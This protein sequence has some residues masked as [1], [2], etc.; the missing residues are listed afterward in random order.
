[1]TRKY[2]VVLALLL[3]LVA[4]ADPIVRLRAFYQSTPAMKAQ[5]KQ[6]VIDRNGHK[7]QEVTG[8]MQL[9]RPGKFRWDYK[10]P[11]VQLIVG[12]G[13][14]VWMYDPD[15]DQVTVR[16]LDK[17]LG[18]SPAA[19]LAGNLDVEKI[20]VL[21][22]VGKQS[23]LEWVQATPKD[24]DSG[25]DHVLLGFRGDQLAEME[26]HD[27]FSQTTVI[28]FSALERNPKLSAKA[29]QFVPPPGADVVGD[30]K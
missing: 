22:D 6:T 7:L 3:P 18:T 17:T 14:K 20:F 9:Q 19:L 12:D 4:H 23:D 2:L 29:F 11:Y 26:L 21:K 1:M 8:V 13:H 15:L 27:N 24:K 25:F 30:V 5:F 28:E 10:T 16:T